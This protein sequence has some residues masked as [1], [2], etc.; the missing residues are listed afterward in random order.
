[1]EGSFFGNFVSF[2]TFVFRK[3][4]SVK[5][6]AGTL[7]LHYYDWAMARNWTMPANTIMH[8]MSMGGVAMGTCHGGGIGH[9]TIADRIIEME[10]V[11]SQGVLQ[12]ISDPE[13]L[14]VA[15]G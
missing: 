10:Y 9:K 12:T 3:R 6:G 13:Q 11:D 4:A 2:Q 1:M 7:N 15:A 14:K 5:F 8:Y